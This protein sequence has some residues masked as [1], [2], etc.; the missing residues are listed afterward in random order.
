MVLKIFSLI[1]KVK[2]APIR[3]NDVWE[4]YAG[5]KSQLPDLNLINFKIKR[6]LY[7]GEETFLNQLELSVLTDNN[8]F[9]LIEE[10]LNEE[11]QINDFKLTPFVSKKRINNY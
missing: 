11:L 7:Y 2:P 9:R 5:I 1:Y 10:K 6:N 8:Q 3:Q 4:L